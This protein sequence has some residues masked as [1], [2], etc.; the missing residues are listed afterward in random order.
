MHLDGTFAVKISQVEAYRF[1][2]D[3]NRIA[4]HMPDVEEVRVEDENNFVLRAKVGVSHIQ[5]TITM[6]LKVVE[7]AEPISAKLTG[8]GTGI[9]SDVD[10]VTH[11]ALDDVGD[12]TTLI[13]WSGD[14]SIG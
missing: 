13:R 4:K 12:G 7:K 8:K 10:M 11:F 6:K 3:P 2:I 5:G 14:A 9:A 1:L